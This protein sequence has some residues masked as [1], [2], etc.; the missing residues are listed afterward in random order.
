MKQQSNITNIEG[1]EGL[2]KTIVDTNTYFINKAQ[3]QVNTA[4]TIRNWVVGCR[5]VEYE[6]NGKDRA[7]YGA[8]LLETLAQGLK[9][10]NLKGMSATNL[11]L[12][13]QFYL[14]YP[15]IRQTVSDE[16]QKAG[17]E[18]RVIGQAVSDILKKEQPGCASLISSL[19]FSHF[20]EL[21]KVEQEAK[22]HF[23]EE[24]TIRNNWSVRTLKR[25]IDSLLY[26]R[27][28]LSKDKAVVREKFG[29]ASENQPEAMFRNTY[30]L[31]FLGLE[32]KETYSES[33][34][35][36]RIISNLQQFLLEL[37]RGFCF[38]ARPLALRY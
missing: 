28:G 13:R 9:E 3:Q 8:Q 11:K 18:L 12:Y 16:L 20:I 38:E 25:A 7:A 4:L 15:Q 32:E 10:L 26:E 30:L 2:V 17:F 33:D 19:S 22:R 29:K 37:G 23:Y 14:A 36:E 27:T 21:L 24:E 31:E 6:Q 5:I 34:L 35:E 1:L